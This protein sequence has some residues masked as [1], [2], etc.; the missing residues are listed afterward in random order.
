MAKKQPR[1]NNPQNTNGKESRH[2][3][4]LNPTNNNPK[5]LWTQLLGITLLWTF[6]LYLPA[7]SNSFVNWDD[8]GYINDNFIIRGL[9]IAH[10]RRMFGEIVLANYHPLTMLSYAFNYALGGENAWGYHFLDMILHTINTGLV[11]A[12]AHRLSKGKLLVAFTVALLFGIHPMH[13][14]SVAWASERKDVLYTLFYVAA[15][16]TYL[17]YT[18]QKTAKHLIYTVLLFVLSLLSK[19]AAVTLPLALLLLDYWQQRNWRDKTIWIEKIPL[20][21]LSLLFGIITVKA[22]APVAIAE[23]TNYSIGQKIMFTAYGFMYYIVQLFAPFNLAALHPYP[24][25][26][27]NAALPPIYMAAPIAAVVLIALVVWLWKRGNK[28]VPFGIAFY[29]LHIILV[30]QFVTVGKAIVAERYSYIAYIGLFF[31]I[32]TYLSNYVDKQ[33]QKRGLIWTAVIAWAAILSILSYQQ[34]GIWKNP[35]TLWTQTLAVHPNC[36]VAYD[37][38]GIYYRKQKKN[39][40]ALADFNKVLEINPKYALTYNN[41][42]NIYFDQQKD[43]L[44]LADYNKALSLDSTH[45]EALV[46]RGV[47]KVR[48]GQADDGMRDFA[49]AEQIDKEFLNL[50]LNRGIAYTM[51]NNHEAAIKDFSS[52]LA[53]KPEHDGIYNSRA[54]SYQNLNQHQKAL[55]DLNQAIKYAPKQGI[56]YLNRSYTYNALGNKAMAKQDALTAQSLGAQVPPAYLQQLN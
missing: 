29:L 16:H 17:T 52:Y 22:Q 56:Y 39:D 53:L 2:A 4:P 24:T 41:R 9:D 35:E 33:P 12:L 6:V 14:E 40:K 54:V 21:A 27:K 5:R 28:V 20:F 19:P 36:D 32:A 31:I 34:I 37:N 43:D 47:I 51:Q 1:S 10:I 42:G 45:T 18:E 8:P 55:E 11:F 25:I 23:L 15:M 49:R 44:A 48:N 26:V 38:R 3:V 7:L 30:L 46:N 50:Y 13:V